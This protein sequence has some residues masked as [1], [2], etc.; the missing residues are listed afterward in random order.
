MNRALARCIVGSLRATGPC[1]EFLARLG[2]FTGSDWERTL[3]WL[4]DSGLALYL[5][6]RVDQ[7]GAHDALPGPIRTR[8][9]RNLASNR[10]RLAAM[11]REFAFLNGR[12]EDA[13]VVFAALKGFTLIPDFCPDASLRLQYDYDY[14][15]SPECES[16][17]RRVLG[18]AGYSHK[19]HSTG[20]EAEGESQFASAPVSLPAKDE[21]FYAAALPRRV[22]LHL[23]LWEPRGE[24]VFPGV[25]GDILDRRRLV[26]WQSMR[27]PV[28]ADDDALLSQVLHAFMHMLSYWCRLSCFLEITYFLAQ[29]YSDTSFWDRFR[30]RVKDCRFL[31]EISGLVFSMA[32]ILFG[33]PVPDEVTQ[34]SARSLVSPLWVREYGEPWAMAS[35]PGSKLTLFM[36]AEFVEDPR[37]WKNVRR[38]RLLPLHRPAQVS[39]V[40]SDQAAQHMKAKWDQWRFVLGRIKFHLGALL[41][42]P[43]HLFHWK[44]IQCRAVKQRSR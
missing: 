19:T 37:V 8:L 42:Y 18:M 44:R 14:L 35:F 43:W 36:H 28:L 40:K 15:V 2:T 22:E 23:G 34:W 24:G 10:Q 11:Q 1:E 32:T 5:L 38:S 21:D 39:E 12:F 6:E 26:E 20:H 33:A 16:M 25:P 4:D 31:P 13:G 41:R 30:C 29:R 17:A 9:E 7:R 3:P 27:F